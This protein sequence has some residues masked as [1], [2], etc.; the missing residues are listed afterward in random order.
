MPNKQEEVKTYMLSM[1]DGSRQKV[2]VPA[3]WRVTFGALYPGKEG[4]SGKSAL[5]FWEGNKENQRAV[6]T[7]VESF[8]DMSIQIEVEQTQSNE[9]VGI[10][11]TELG[12]KNVVMR[13]EVKQWVNP[14][15]PKTQ[16]NGLQVL[17]LTEGDLA[18]ANK[19]INQAQE[20]A[21]NPSGVIGA[22]RQRR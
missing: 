4:N 3:K 10:V 11:K 16:A 21:E 15:D 22:Q 7:E 8:R 13:A 9:H 5:R 17:R 19:V 6:F 18:G 20:A 12:D 1:R 14:D 2:T